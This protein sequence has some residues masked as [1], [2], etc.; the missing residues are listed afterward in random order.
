MSNLLTVLSSSFDTTPYTHILPSLERHL[1]STADLL[2]LEPVDVAKRAQV[3][4][5]EV[6][7][8]V[9]AVIEALHGDLLVKSID[10]SSSR[11]HHAADVAQR[12]DVISTLDDAL[13]E[14][15][16]G[17]IAC[18]HLTEIVGER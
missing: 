6:K 11:L 1:I 12:W 2:T 4:P 3:P 8:L 14:A 18:G 16:N 17:G 5:G 9:D 10:L 7:K 15:L 13:D